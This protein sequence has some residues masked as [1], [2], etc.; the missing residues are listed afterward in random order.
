MADFTLCNLCPRPGHLRNSVEVKQI[1]S[2]VR[3]FHSEKFT[4][5]R[6]RLCGSLHSKEEI[7]SA[8]YYHYY[9]FKEQKLDPWTWVAYGN[10]LRRLIREGV[11]QEHEILDYGCGSGLFVSFLHKKGYKKAVGYDPYVRDFA[12]EKILGKTYETIVA[13]DV[14]E[15]VDDPRTFLML[16]SQRLRPGGILCIGTPNAQCIDL[17]Q[18]EKFALPL[19][20]PYHRHV[21]S[22][23]TLVRLGLDLGL[24]VGKIY[25]RYYFDTLFPLANSR[26]LQSYVRRAGNVIDAAFEKPKISMILTSPRLLF[27]ALFGYFFPP[28]TEAMVFFRQENS[29]ATK[30]LKI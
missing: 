15:H 9:P 2:I 10:R 22:E 14:I 19:H 16:L 29:R 25:H 5:W 13:Q 1:D 6:C 17:F 4:V 11:N 12:D 30:T 3:K 21:L 20:Q 8:N 28:K 23:D 27:Y 18:P 26:F 7:D 24:R